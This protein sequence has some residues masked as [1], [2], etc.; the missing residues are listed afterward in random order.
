MRTPHTFL[1]LAA[2][3]VLASCM[4]APAQ[5]PAEAT[6]TVKGFT[7][8]DTLRMT[9]YGANIRDTGAFGR[10]L[11]FD[12]SIEALKDVRAGL[13]YYSV[14]GLD[15]DGREYTPSAM[16]GKSPSLPTRDEMKGGERVRGWVSYGY[17]DGEMPK[18]VALRF[19][20]MVGKPLVLRFGGISVK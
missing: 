16:T 5:R 2:A 7:Q 12:V 14:V 11:S 13:G 8:T 10:Q 15:D 17:N 20:P 18:I 6:G 4:S 9:I 1:S 3:V 19:A